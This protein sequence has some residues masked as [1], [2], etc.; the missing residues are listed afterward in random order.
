MVHSLK[1]TNNFLLTLFTVCR[2]LC[3]TGMITDEHNIH[4]KHLNKHTLFQRNSTHYLVHKNIKNTLV[5]VFYLNK[6]FK[7]SSTCDTPSPEKGTATIRN[8]GD[9]ITNA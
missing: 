4:I 3:K 1:T 7:N 2:V 5:T 8:P 9:C 6:R